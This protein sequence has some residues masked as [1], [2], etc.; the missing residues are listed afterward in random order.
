MLAPA[1]RGYSLTPK[2]LLQLAGFYPEIF[3][4]EPG[5]WE[6]WA[7]V[8]HELE[9][10]RILSVAND[11]VGGLQRVVGYECGCSKGSGIALSQEGRTSCCSWTLSPL[12]GE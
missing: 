7:Q 2:P 4:D 1:G 10:T 5:V 3:H 8:T 12:V 9:D 6:I 11:G